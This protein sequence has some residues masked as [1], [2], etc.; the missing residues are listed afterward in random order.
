MTVAM[1]CLGDTKDKSES[2]LI[3]MLNVMFSS[4]METDEKIEI[5]EN[6]FHLPM[7]EKLKEEVEEVG[8]FSD[9]FERQGMERGMK[10]GIEKGI[11]HNQISLITSKLKKNKT[12]EQIADE[13]ELSIEK[14]EEY[15]Q[16]INASTSAKI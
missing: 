2:E 1:V 9:Y 15:I 8:S 7:T 16:M 5:L 13:V 11:E 6:E 4:R 12:I 3:N 10:K 14:V